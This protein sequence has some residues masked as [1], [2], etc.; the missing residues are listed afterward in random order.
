VPLRDSVVTQTVTVTVG[1]RRRH[2]PGRRPG[3]G[4]RDG[5][6]RTGP[7]PPRR[8]GGR[9]DKA[10]RKTRDSYRHGLRET[11]S[12][13]RLITGGYYARRISSYWSRIKGCGQLLVN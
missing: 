9:G 7:G 6:G 13:R 2:G 10:K 11:S 1:D 12:R 3:R 5:R 4:H 8:G